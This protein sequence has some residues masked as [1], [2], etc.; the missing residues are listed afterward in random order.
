MRALLPY[1]ISGAF[2]PAQQN[3]VVE[4]VSKG[5]HLPDIFRELLQIDPTVFSTKGRVMGFTPLAEIEKAM[6]RRVNE[7]D[8]GALVREAL[9]RMRGRV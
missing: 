3:A 6:Q 2:L 1:I 4:S 5:L 7:I 9:D 8:L